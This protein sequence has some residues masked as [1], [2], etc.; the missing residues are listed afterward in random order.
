S[1]KAIL[2]TWLFFIL[3]LIGLGYNA[4]DRLRPEAFVQLATEQIQ[5]NIPNGVLVVGEVDYSFS[6]DFNIKLK[7]VTLL[8]DDVQVAKIGEFE[9]KIPWWLLITHRGTAQ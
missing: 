2:W 1:M 8:R 9:L 7:Q 6:I 3:M 5:K 4:Y